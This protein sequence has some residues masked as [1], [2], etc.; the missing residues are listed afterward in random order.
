MAIFPQST[1]ILPPLPPPHL[2][3]WGGQGNRNF[4][5][6]KC[7]TSNENFSLQNFSKFSELFYY[8]PPKNLKP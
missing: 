1:F 4:S 6:K 5:E 8:T 7:S 2:R 3:M